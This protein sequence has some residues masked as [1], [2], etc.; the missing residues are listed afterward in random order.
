MNQGKSGKTGRW[1]FFVAATNKGHIIRDF[2]FG[3]KNES[4][5]QIAI[6]GYKEITNS[7]MDS[8]MIFDSANNYYF[9]KAP[10]DFKFSP[11]ASERAKHTRCYSHRHNGVAIQN[12]LP[13]CMKCRDEI[14][15]SANALRIG[16]FR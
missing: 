6:R 9:K 1:V 12:G 8:I 3:E 13:D 5:M 7:P 14:L 15:S 2:A 16:V 11:D 10:L 4:P